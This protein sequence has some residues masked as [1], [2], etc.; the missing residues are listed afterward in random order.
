MSSHSAGILTSF[1]PALLYSEYDLLGNAPSP[2]SH[3]DDLEAL[4]TCIAEDKAK[5]NK[6][7][8]VIQ[9]RAWKLAD[10]FRSEG[11]HNFGTACAKTR[12]HQY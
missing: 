2:F 4:Q 1:D 7:S 12:Y 11:E 10:I 5:K 9:H 3:S 8:V 6:E